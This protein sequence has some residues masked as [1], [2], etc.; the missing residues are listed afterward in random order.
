VAN[1][2]QQAARIAKRLEAIMNESG[3]AVLEAVGA[4]AEKLVEMQQRLVPVRHGDLRDSIKS[5][6]ITTGQK[7]G[8]RV[9]AGSN[10]A[11]YARWVEFGTV[12]TAAEAF[13]F[14][15]YRASRKQIRAA[16]RK[17]IRIAVRGSAH[18]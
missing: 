2:Q 11:F 18:Q 8:F 13:F 15:A 4:Q 16:V 14:P 10:K 6:R 1:S 3:P 5:E 17:A 9:S 7:L 12:K